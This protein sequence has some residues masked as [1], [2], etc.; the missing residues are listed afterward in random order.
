MIKLTV[1]VAQNHV[2]DIST[3]S[4]I[5]FS[6]FLRSTIVILIS[7]LFPYLFPS[8]DRYGMQTFNERVGRILMFLKTILQES[9]QLFFSILYCMT[10]IL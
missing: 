6:M 9:V 4:S 7:N 8:L 3:R 5:K 1:C 2:E 10:F